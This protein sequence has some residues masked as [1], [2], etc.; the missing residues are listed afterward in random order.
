M[1]QVSMQL[2]DR[3]ARFY[4]WLALWLLI[5][6]GAPLGAAAQA[7]LPSA[8]DTIYEVRLH[9]GS[10]IYGRLESADAERV[11]IVSVT[12]VRFEL[13]RTQIRSFHV[14]AGRMEG[15]RYWGPD[16]NPTRLFFAPTGR[17]LRAGDGYVGVYMILFPM[18]A[19]GIT[20]R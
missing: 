6:A 20:D 13:K 17:S 2:Q 15:N 5:A 1:E 7:P 14:A 16:P 8:A 11:V 19:Y 4:A 10:T 12:G 18:A 9:D 3:S